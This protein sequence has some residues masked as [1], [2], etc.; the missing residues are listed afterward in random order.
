MAHKPSKSPL[1]K[2]WKTFGGNAFGHW[3]VSRIVCFKAPYFSSIKPTFRDIRPGRVEVSFKKRR[4]VQNHIGT[5]HA[6]AMCNAA[7]LAGGTCL[8]VSLNSDFRWIPVGMTVHYLKMAKTDLRAVC[9]VPAYDWD[10]A[11]DVVMPVS[12]T[13]AK[14]VEVFHADITMRISL[15]SK[16]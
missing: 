8:D 12:V 15:R 2:L 16:A 14:G 9:E 13:D 4:R 5:V 11:Q 7:E 3:L 6:I 10:T 1:L